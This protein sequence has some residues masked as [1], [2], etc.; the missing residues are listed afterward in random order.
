M[1]A[2][3][4]AKV[5]AASGLVFVLLLVAT[6]IFGPGLDPPGFNEPG[7]IVTYIQD[8]QDELQ[9]ATAMSTAAGAAFLLFLG[10]VVLALRSAEG[11]PGRLSAAAAAGG[12]A[13]VA[14]AGIGVVASQTAAVTTLRDLSTNGQDLLSMWD[15]RTAAFALAG[16]GFAVLAWAAGVLTLRSGALPNPLGLFSIVAAVFVLGV[17]IFGAFQQTGAF[18]PYDGVLSL[19]SLLV[20]VVWVGVVSLAL[21][22]SPVYKRA[23]R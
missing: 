9:S 8:N 17:S 15:A 5:G 3:D 11:A 16:L 4:W 21:I 20:I 14:L 2:D 13:F 6:F 22:S 23:R 18:S 10:S 12:I 1:S 7:Q 19:I